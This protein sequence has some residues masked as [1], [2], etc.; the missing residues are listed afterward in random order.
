MKMYSESHENLIASWATGLSETLKG[1][2]EK[3]LEEHKKIKEKV[4]ANIEFIHEF[5]KDLSALEEA[6]KRIYQS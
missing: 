4:N 5:Q 3:W 6:R 2:S 1:D